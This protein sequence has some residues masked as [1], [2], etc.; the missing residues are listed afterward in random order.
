MKFLRKSEIKIYLLFGVIFICTI[1]F[2]LYNKPYFVENIENKPPDVCFYYTPSP[3]IKD[4][5]SGGE[6]AILKFIKMLNNDGINAALFSNSPSDLTLIPFT[7]TIS[8]NTVVVYAEIVHGNPLD[9]KNVCRWILYDPYS[10]GGQELIDSWGKNDTLCSYGNYDGGLK[11]DI[12]VNVVEFNED[13]FTINNTIKTK[14]Y[15]LIHKALLNGWNQEELDL[16][17]SYLKQLG[18]EEINILQTHKMNELMQDCC[19]FVSF[20]LNTYVS[21]M[22]VL[23]GSLSMIK[24]S[25]TYDHSYKYIL[26]NRGSYGTIG[27]K[28]FDLHLLN[29][30]YNYNKRL[31]ECNLYR[32]YI[33]TCNNIDEFVNYYKLN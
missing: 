28:P 4:T 6:H 16:E 25:N 27:I 2:Y 13:I 30:P 10:R 17:I 18:F 26:D 5:L 19:V 11:C 29:Q 15:F 14:K 24:K 8:D 31:S 20:D 21:N 12:N 22:A 32:E 33:K 9:A 3:E 7:N 23:C 1:I